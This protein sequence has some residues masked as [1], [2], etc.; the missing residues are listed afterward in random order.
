MCIRDRVAYDR[1]ETPRLG[2][3]TAQLVYHFKNIEGPRG[4]WRFVYEAPTQILKV[5]VPLDFKSWPLAAARSS[6]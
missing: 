5:A 1:F 3:G 6:D 2:D 4:G